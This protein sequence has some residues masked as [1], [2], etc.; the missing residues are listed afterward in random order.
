MNGVFDKNHDSFVV[1]FIGD[2]F[3][4][5][6]NHLVCWE[7]FKTVL[8]VLRELKLF[9]EVKKRAFSLEDL[10]LLGQVISKD[11]NFVLLKK[12]EAIVEWER[13]TSVRRICSF[14]GFDGYY[15]K[16]TV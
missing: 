5:S 12:R 1:A 3:V 2:I 14:L 8:K 4:H 7:N 16:F 10:S 15:H 9:A 13:L 11:G 6:T